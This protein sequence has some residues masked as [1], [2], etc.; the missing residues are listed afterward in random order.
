MEIAGARGRGTILVPIAE[1]TGDVFTALAGKFLYR[2]FWAGR[3]ALMKKLVAG[4]TGLGVRQRLPYGLVEVQG[5]KG[6]LIDDVD[7][8][9][10]VV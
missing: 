2:A 1:L 9:L 4:M 7:H 6:Y 8:F 5:H 3:H 10:H